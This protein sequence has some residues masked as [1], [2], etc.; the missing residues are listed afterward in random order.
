MIQPKNLYL[1]FLI[2]MLLIAGCR[3]LSIEKR[4]LEST[5][6]VALEEEIFYLIF[7]RSFFDSNGDR[8]GDLNGVTQQLDYIQDLGITS[9]IMTPLYPSSYY[10]NYFTHDYY[11]IDSEFGTVDD[12]FNMVKEIHRRGMKFYMDTELQYVIKEHPWFGESFQNPNSEFSNYVMYKD[13]LNTEPETMVFDLKGLKSY[14]GYYT[15]I[16]I[17]NLY[18]EEVAEYIK[19]YYAFWV[20]PNGDGSFEDGVDGFRIDAFHNDQLKKGILTNL[21]Q[22]FWKPIIDNSKRIN[23]DVTFVAEQATWDD[24]D[25]H[26][27][28]KKSGVEV[29]YSFGLHFN[30]NNPTILREYFK[31]SKQDLPEGKNMFAFLDQHDTDRVLSKI[32]NNTAKN[33]Q[34]ATLTYLMK[35][36]PYIYYGQEIGM[37]GKREELIRHE[38]LL[39]LSDGLDISVREPF[40]WTADINEAGNALW[41]ENVQPYWE[42]KSIKSKDGISV[43]EQINNPNSLLNFYRKILKFRSSNSAFTTGEFEIIQ[44]ENDS[45]FTYCRWNNLS[46][47]ILAFNLT[48]Q[49]TSMIINTEELPFEPSENSWKTVFSDDESQF[50]SLNENIEIQMVK[51]GFIILESK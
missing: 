5:N 18:K 32:G 25:A 50:S 46:G 9:I 42:K 38:S 35:F 16:T 47:Y 15:D 11:G 37:T 13:S 7:P 8:I 10:H 17:V 39:E 43:E 40:E 49:A 1:I 33:K 29:A 36:I 12:Y 51:N 44:H 19:D 30:V 4:T 26:S 27:W 6:K 22:G 23:P 21:A 31:W 28:M 34:L 41:F 20:D 14:D 2:L 45:T 3:Q 24:G 48:D